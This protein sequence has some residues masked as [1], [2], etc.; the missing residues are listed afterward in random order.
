MDGEEFLEDSDSESES[1]SDCLIF[2]KGKKRDF[3]ESEESKK[4][5]P[6]QVNVKKFKQQTKVEREKDAKEKPKVER[7]RERC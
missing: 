7:E 5:A 3:L 6:K 1:S 2:M 4:T